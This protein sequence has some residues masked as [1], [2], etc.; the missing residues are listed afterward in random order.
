MECAECSS[1]EGQ[2][3]VSLE[4]VQKIRDEIV[5]A[6]SSG[7]VPEDMIERLKAAERTHEN[8]LA[9]L[10]RHRASHWSPANSDSLRMRIKAL[11]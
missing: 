4:E 8:C 6:F 11:G 2:M 5:D 7:P 3:K 9:A 1:L 10:E